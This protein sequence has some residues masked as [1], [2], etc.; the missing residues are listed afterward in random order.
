MPP[1]TLDA[2]R[3]RL[4][5]FT[6]ADADW[7]Y[8]VSLDPAM[9]R[10]IDLPSPYL[11]E[12]AEHFVEHLAV[13]GWNGGTRAEFLVE[14]AET[15]RRLARVGLHL[16]G[17]RTAEIGYWADPAARARGVTSAA[18]AAACRWAF[19]DERLELIEW[20]AEVGNHASRRVAEKVGFRI[21]GTLR[22]RLRHRGERVDAWVGSLLPGEIIP[23]APARPEADGAR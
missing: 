5:P 15:A 14:D 7:V 13:A 23:P 6:G 18:V 11:R 19:D 4:R 10:F 12:H 16:R 22:R 8:R 20:R 1:I 3:L 17:D 2:G 9:R 21:E